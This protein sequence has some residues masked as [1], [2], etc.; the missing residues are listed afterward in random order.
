MNTREEATECI[1]KL[2]NDVTQKRK[3]NM[4]LGP[5]FETRIVGGYDVDKRCFKRP[6][7]ALIKIK[8]LSAILG[9]PGNCMGSIINKKFVLTAAHCFCNPKYGVCV[10]NNGEKTE[11]LY[12]SGHFKFKKGT[13]ESSAD[14][15]MPNRTIVL[16]PGKSASYSKG[17][18]Q[19]ME[20]QADKGGLKNVKSVIIHP[21]YIF[22][23][24]EQ[25]DIALVEVMEA[26]DFSNPLDISPI[27]L[28]SPNLQSDNVTVY[29]TGY[30][31]IFEAKSGS[32]QCN[33]GPGGPSE[34]Q[35]CKQFWIV[36][37]EIYDQT[38]ECSYTESPARRDRDC[39]QLRK[40]HP[41]L[42]LVKSKLTIGN[43][44]KVC[45]PLE[46]NGQKAWCATCLEEADY[47]EAG[48]CKPLQDIDDV[49]DDEIENRQDFSAERGWG[50]CDKMCYTSTVFDDQLQEAALFALSKEECDERTRRFLEDERLMSKRPNTQVEICAAKR[51]ESTIYHYKREGE[52]YVLVENVTEVVW[53][54]SD[55][56]K[57]DSGGPLWIVNDQKVFLVGVTNRGTGCARKDSYGIYARVSYH[58]DW[59][60][61]VAGSG[62]CAAEVKPVDKEKESTGDYKATETTESSFATKEEG[63]DL[64]NDIDDDTIN[65]DLSKAYFE[66][67]AELKS[68]NKEESSFEKDS[69]KLDTVFGKSEELPDPNILNDEKTSS[70][71]KVVSKHRNKTKDREADNVIKMTGTIKLSQV[72]EN[73]TS[74]ITEDFDINSNYTKTAEDSTLISNFSQQ[75][76]AKEKQVNATEQPRLQ[77]SETMTKC[78]DSNQNGSCN[79]SLQSEVE[80]EGSNQ[81]HDQSDTVSESNSF[82]FQNQDDNFD[83]G[84]RAINR[85]DKESQLNVLKSDNQAKLLDESR[86]DE[87]SKITNQLKFKEIHSNQDKDLLSQVKE[88]L[89]EKMD[90]ED[91][92]FLF[93]K[94][95]TR[96]TS[97]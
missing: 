43:Q 81:E 77:D 90:K 75:D 86:K 57:G 94:I 88:S 34:F 41:E 46:S 53:G 92:E 60:H 19:G 87:K 85:P 79:F 78:L 97:P 20:Y 62:S 56:C 29:V 3:K 22:R 11:E 42:A 65:Q 48:Y 58:W 74:V 4:N 55:T 35:K 91:V 70:G 9:E 12:P 50:Y 93:F 18:V 72:D 95:R 32:T 80:Q 25:N 69:N 31:Q 63:L 76:N 13:V 5:E 45:Y 24:R 28:G 39:K 96:K 1:Q 61:E 67:S 47:G 37:E 10:K 14:P 40:V 68:V 30:G 84:I 54:G 17:L 27:C 23:E 71:R 52:D 51:Q 6:S 15:T 59:I 16:L 21:E 73:A 83:S 64:E 33:T 38:Q 89:K 26:F 8:P 7:L 44:T 66:E 2:Q 82:N 36:D 49:T